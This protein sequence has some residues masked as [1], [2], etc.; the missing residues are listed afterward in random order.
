MSIVPHTQGN[1]YSP[2]EVAQHH[3]QRHAPLYCAITTI[4]CSYYDAPLSATLIAAFPL[5]LTAWGGY[6]ST[7]PSWR[8]ALDIG[9]IGALYVPYGR[10]A[11]AAVDIS[12]YAFLTYSRLSAPHMSLE[13]AKRVFDIPEDAPLILDTIEATYA[14]KRE[15]WTG[16]IEKTNPAVS[17]QLQHSFDKVKQAYEVL[18]EH[19]K[20]QER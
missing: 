18:T 15:F 5:R 17:A 16:T 7:T 3:I 4:M 11:S 20:E 19:V 6:L 12:H 14:R 8:S 9:A 10:I 13:E 2:F 1:S